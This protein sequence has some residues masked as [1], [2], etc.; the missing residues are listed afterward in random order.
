MEERKFNPEPQ[1]TKLDD[2]LFR[3]EKDTHATSDI[4]PIEQMQLMANQMQQLISMI[5]QAKNQ[6]AQAL[7]IAEWYNIRVGI[8]NNAKEKLNLDF[9]KMEEINVDVL[10]N[11]IDCNPEDLPRIDVEPETDEMDEAMKKALKK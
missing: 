7:K 1:F 10:K 3:V 11:I 5:T 4:K 6:Q 8:M 2:G 9:K